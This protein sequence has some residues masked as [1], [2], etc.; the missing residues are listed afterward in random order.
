MAKKKKII[1][2]TDRID[3]PDFNLENVAC[4]IDT[5]AATSTLHCRDVHLLEKDGTEYLCFRLYDPRFKIYDRQQYRFSQFRVRR[6]RSSNGLLDERYSIKTTINL[7]QRKIKTEFTLSFRE[8]M[9]FPILLGKRFLRN[10]FLVDVSQNNLNYNEK[11]A[12]VQAE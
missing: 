7:Y 1:G 6:V 11:T 5:G 10:R 3:L 12:S 2:A 9:K 8:K 4:K